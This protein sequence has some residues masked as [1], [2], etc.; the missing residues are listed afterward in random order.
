MFRGIQ[1]DGVAFPVLLAAALA[2]RRELGG[3]EVSN[4]VRRT[5]AFALRTGPSSPQDRWEEDPGLNAF[6]LAVPC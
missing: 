5:L 4:M 3:I 1:L 6:T 2:E